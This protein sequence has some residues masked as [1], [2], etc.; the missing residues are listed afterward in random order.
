MRHSSARKNLFDNRHCASDCDS[1]NNDYES[2]AIQSP[3]QASGTLCSSDLDSDSNATHSQGICNSIQ[4]EGLTNYDQLYDEFSN[5]TDFTSD[6]S[7]DYSDTLSSESELD[8]EAAD[9]DLLDDEIVCENIDKSMYSE[10]ELNALCLVSYFQRHNSSSI[11]KKDLLGLLRVLCPDSSQIHDFTYDQV[12]SVAGNT[13]YVTVDYCSIC[14]KNFPE[15]PDVFRCE[16]DGCFGLRYMG[17]LTAQ[18]KASR[19]PVNSFVLADVEKQLQFILERK[20]TWDSIQQTKHRIIQT[21]V[22]SEVTDISDGQFYRTLCQPGQFLNDSNNIS[23]VFNTDGIPLYTSSNVKLWPVFLAINELPP[24]SRFAREN[25]IIAAIWQGKD[26]P[27]FSQYM[28]AFGEQ[29]CKLYEEGV[30]IMPCGSL[31]TLYVRLGVFVGTMDLQAKAYV[32][33]MTMH[34]GEFGCSTCEESGQSVKQGKG[35]ARSYP[36]RSPAERPNIRNSDDVKYVKGPNATRSVRQKGI[37]GMTGLAAM[38]WLDVVIG[39]VPDYMHCVLLGVTK[40]LMYKFFS[41]TNSNKPYFVGKHLKKISKRMHS[42]C[43]PDF[44]ERIP[45][46]LERNYSQFK[47]TEFQ[48]WLLFYSLPCLNGYLE[49]VYLQHLALLSEGIYLLLGDNITEDNLLKAESLLDSFYEQFAAL[50]GEGSCGLNVHNVGAHMVFYTRMWGPLWSW[51]C[52]PFEDWNAALLQSIHGTGNVTK[53]CLHL[54]EIQLKLNCINLDSLPQGRAH[55]YLVKMKKRKTWSVTN[56]GENVATAGALKSCTNLDEDDI[57]LILSETGCQNI[58]LFKKSL[59]VQ[60]NGQKLYSEGYS[61]MKKRICNVVRCKNGQLRKVMY[62]LVKTDTNCVLAFAKKLEVH[63]QSFICETNSHHIIRVTETTGKVIFPVED[64][65]EK[66]FFM[67]I[68]GRHY[69]ACMPNLIGH[70]IFK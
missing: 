13:N 52:F 2:P 69:V 1:D 29:M 34:N 3:V 11:A 14:S 57:L 12:M 35:Y 66:V 37:C 61:R 10:T 23:A 39:V 67:S 6:S 41:P 44:I 19:Q 50:Y 33:N 63:Q 58:Q 54:H 16:T 43:P 30:K 45:R 21:T 27:P 48:T 24:S 55:S 51:S 5:D 20:G 49:D 15:D 31:E 36:Y 62:F 65:I 4:N 47:A 25:M 8:S 17:H 26:R 22:C 53:Q 60:V 64:I 7:T 28:N 46:D 32:L 38:P 59:R 9:Y 56:S 68:D 42:I 40:T 70:S 18:Q